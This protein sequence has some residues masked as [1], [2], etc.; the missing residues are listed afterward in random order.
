MVWLRYVT[1]RYVTLGYVKSGKVRLVSSRIDCR[2][3]LAILSKLSRN[4][5]KI[6]RVTVEV[7]FCRANVS[8]PVSGILITVSI[9][10]VGFTEFSMA[11]FES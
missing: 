6:R 3:D 5:S 9:K 4:L 1:L 11:L 8:I 10:P 7:K 2:S